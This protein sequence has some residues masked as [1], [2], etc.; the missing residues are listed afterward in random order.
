MSG[1]HFRYYRDQDYQLLRAFCM[2]F[3]HFH[4]KLISVQP[5]PNGQNPCPQFLD[6]HSANYL[7]AIYYEWWGVVTLK[8]IRHRFVPD[9][10]MAHALC[11]FVHARGVYFGITPLPDNAAQCKF[12]ALHSLLLLSY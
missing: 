11:V 1:L 7:N 3:F 9:Q 10:S 12:R 8:N 2:G 6:K 5:V 4:R